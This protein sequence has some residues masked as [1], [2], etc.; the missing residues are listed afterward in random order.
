M[1]KSS[2]SS[3]GII[4]V[5]L[6]TTVAAGCISSG[7]EGTTT[8]A[9]T[10]VAPTTTPEPETRVIVDMKGNEV[11]IPLVIEKVAMFGGPSGQIPHILG[12]QDTIC[13]CSKGHKKSTLMAALDP[14]MMDIPAPRATNGVINVEELL[15]ADPDFVFAGPT[16]KEVVVT[17]TDY[18]V[19]DY[20]SETDGRFADVKAE[21]TFFGMVYGKEDE[22]QEYCDYL[23]SV[24]ALLSE[25]LS[26]L[27][28]SEKVVVF[29]GYSTNHLITCGGDTYMN[30]RI[31]AAGCINAAAEVNTLG[32][33]Q[34]IHS[35]LDEISM[36]QLLAWDPDIVIIDTGVPDDI[37]DDTMWKDVS[38]VVNNQVYNQPNGMFIFNRPSAESAV[39]YTLWLATTAYPDRFSDISIE[40]E[41]VRFYSEI[42]DYEL[43]AEELAKVLDGSSAYVPC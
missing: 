36:E 5:L 18:V 24:L 3:I 2:I 27:E 31:E 23:D 10:T 21:V 17:N 8:T 13:A 15:M 39:L 29:N 7:D 32:Q 37:Y 42:F 43:S 11:E 12:V 14:H 22:A 9:P 28:Q 20:M 6:L 16:D 19:V 35:G 40:D 30:E 33:K 34:G 26:D 1:K 38:A 4:I 41:I 25:R